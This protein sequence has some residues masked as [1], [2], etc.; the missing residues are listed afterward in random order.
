MLANRELCIDWAGP[1]LFEGVKNDVM[2]R[3]GKI[4]EGGQAIKRCLVHGSKFRLMSVQ[5]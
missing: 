2:A 4:D 5:A 1:F 3:G